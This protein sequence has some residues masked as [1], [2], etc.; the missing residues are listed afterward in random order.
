MIKSD[1][2][3]IKNLQNKIFQAESNYDKVKY[4]AEW[5]VYAF[6]AYYNLS[7]KT[8]IKAKSAFENCDWQAAFD[9]SKTR[10]FMY[11]EKIYDLAPLILSAFPEL[12]DDEVLWHE[13]EAH[14]VPLVQGRYESDFACSFLHSTRRVI[15][16][17]EWR[18]VE[19]S[20][21]M[22][23]QQ[24]SKNDWAN[25]QLNLIL[26]EFK[27]KNIISEK[28]IKEIL[29]IPHFS[30]QFRDLAA[31]SKLASEHANM[32][33]GLDD[34]KSGPNKIIQMVNA[35]FFRNRGC[36]LVGRIVSQNHSAQPF[37]LAL[38]NSQ[39][40][41]FIDAV[42][43]KEAHAQIIFSSTLANFHVTNPHYHELSAFLHSIMPKRPLGHHYTT[44]GFNH[45]G[46]I[47][48]L[49]ELG[50]EIK[51][52]KEKLETA[53][54]FKGTVAIGFATLSSAYI[55]KVIRDSPTKE[56]KWGVFKGIE[57]V[58]T[59]YRQ[60]HEI[61]RTGS[62]LDNIIYH[63]LKIPKHWFAP[64]LLD[65][66]LKDAS[67]SV[68]VNND[69]VIFKHLI[70]QLKMIPLPVFLATA[71]N[72][73][74][75]RA[76]INL[77]HCIRNNAAANIFNKDLDCRN[78]GVSHFLKIY[79]FDY[80]AVEPL[81]EIKVRTN[82]DRYDGEEDVPEWFFE[83]G[84]I[85]LPEEIEVGLRIHDRALKRLFCDVHADLLTVSYW[86]NMQK[87][88]LNNELPPFRAYP[89]TTRLRHFAPV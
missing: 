31:D 59:K 57:N 53:I 78:Y 7:V 63:N 48:V 71:S 28:I 89:E 22:H 66:L 5:L 12:A 2:G 54:G 35:G 9:L 33:L 6:D 24:Y 8:P 4:A 69:N 58:L 61:N 67:L 47:A 40:G 38:L 44:I 50:E 14:F 79:L 70:V 51:T 37:V 75:Q 81:T 80:D 86:E 21:I 23:K 77:G 84:H 19:Y 13:I 65:E 41:I 15:N 87:L 29:Q 43:T 17:G 42:L 85:F 52:T 32:M 11:S 60:V 39:Q 36:Y 3:P 10:L 34:Q 30:V 74:A 20:T 46:K 68:S 73:Q 18:P 56:Y 45:I 16:K 88:L 49:E 1:I 72:G 26:K 27:I 25:Q 76:I 64:I 62:M 55:L 82:L 83:D